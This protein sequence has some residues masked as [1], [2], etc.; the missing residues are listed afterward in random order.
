MTK[1]IDNR[2][3]D[4][5]KPTAS[6]A[7]SIVTLCNNERRKLYSSLLQDFGKDYYEY[8]SDSLEREIIA[9]RY[10]L[11]NKHHLMR[12]CAFLDDT[13]VGYMVC[14][15]DSDGQLQLHGIY[16]DSSVHGM[17]IGSKLMKYIFN[18]H[19]RKVCKL[20]VISQNT[21][22]IKF[23]EKFGF[24]PNGRTLMFR[25]SLK[26]IEMECT[27]VSTDKKEI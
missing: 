22:A 14:S 5:R 1:V 4:I 3:I 20:R 2:V 12:Y 16:V 9:Y 8:N 13:L 11:Q 10:R 27:I 23:Y 15:V 25:E 7:E 6:D 21:D 24:K 17:G 19:D 18:L 26:K